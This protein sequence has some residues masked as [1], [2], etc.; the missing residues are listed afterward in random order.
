M[1]SSWKSAAQTG[2]YISGAIL[3]FKSFLKNL[4]YLPLCCPVQM[5]GLAFR[6]YYHQIV[7]IDIYPC[8]KISSNN[9]SEKTRLHTHSYTSP[10]QALGVGTIE[11]READDWGPGKKS[12]SRSSLILLVAC[13]LFPWSP[14]TESLEQATHIQQ[15]K[16]VGETQ[17]NGLTWGEEPERSRKRYIRV[18]TTS[19]V[20]SL[21]R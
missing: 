17:H 9:I 6:M 18:Q 2:I 5:E 10:L 20:Y 14:L 7:Q 15:W 11:K 8:V 16:A 3:F 1:C 4:A 13:S 19:F 21:Q 12:R